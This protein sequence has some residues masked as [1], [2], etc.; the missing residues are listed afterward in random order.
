MSKAFFLLNSLLLVCAFVLS[1]LGGEFTTMLFSASI[2]AYCFFY[3]V[4]ILIN[5]I[6]IKL[7]KIDFNYRLLV[8]PLFNL[9]FICAVFQFIDSQQQASDAAVKESL[10]KGSY[11]Q[12]TSARSKITRTELGVQRNY[13]LE[14]D[15]SCLSLS[16][17]SYSVPKVNYTYCGC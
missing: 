2:F 13:F 12:V 16:S 9:L 6:H 10:F 14:H 17:P 4:Y 7:K 8:I 11:C 1:L 15:K 3:P 5:L